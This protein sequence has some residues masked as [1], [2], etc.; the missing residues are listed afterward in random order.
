MALKKYILPQN[1]YVVIRK[2]RQLKN[3][4]FLYEMNSEDFV[5][6]TSLEAALT[7][8]KKYRCRN[9]KLTKFTRCL[10]KHQY[11]KMH[12]LKYW[13]KLKNE[14]SHKIEDRLQKINT[15]I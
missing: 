7:K 12:N 15:T 14:N 3:K 4:F 5:S 2:C 10:T 11:K 6:K 9:Y 13:I 8:C 1:C